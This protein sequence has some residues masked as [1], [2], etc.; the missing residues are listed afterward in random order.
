MLTCSFCYY[1][2]NPSQLYRP[3]CNAVS[4]TGQLQQC[5]RLRI[6]RQTTRIQA[7]IVRSAEGTCSKSVRAAFVEASINGTAKRRYATC[8]GAV[9]IKKTLRKAQKKVA[10]E[11]PELGQEV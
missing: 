7:Y 9:D 1:E 5:I 2:I 3:P 10:T 6:N 8:I 4:L 11:R